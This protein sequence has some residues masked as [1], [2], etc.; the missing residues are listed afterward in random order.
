[1]IC[2]FEWSGPDPTGWDTTFAAIRRSTLLQS[3]AYADALCP[4]MGQRPLRALIRIDGAVAGLVQLQEAAIIR[5]AIH[6]LILDRGPLWC[7]GFGSLTQTAA[8][9]TTLC[10]AFPQRPGRRRRLLPEVPLRQRDAVAKVADMKRVIESQPY[11]TIWCDL[12][13]SETDLR[14]RLK[15]KWRNMLNKAERGQLQVRWDWTGAALPMFLGGYTPDKQAKGYAGASPKTL[16]HLAKGFAP[17]QAMGIAHVQGPAGDVLAGVLVFVHGRAATYQAGWVTEV[18]R[19]SA[20]NHMAL[21]D[22]LRQLRSRGVTDL[23]LGGVNDAA[24]AGVKRF[25]SGL[26]GELVELVGQFR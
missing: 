25:K 21:W 20:A 22:T 3:R 10:Q 6:A 12:T 14:A 17:Q 9:F 1:M 2:T 26:G 24:A 11:Q 18:G 8:F 5:R 19:A 15:P 13:G 23:D 7:E 4:P 16:I